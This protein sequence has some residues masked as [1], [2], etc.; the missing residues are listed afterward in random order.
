[1]TEKKEN[2]VH[3]EVIS[4]TRIDSGNLK[5][6]V[7]VKI[8]EITIHDFRVIQQPN[9]RAYVSMPQRQYTTSDGQRGFRPL[10]DMPD[11]L[12]QKVRDCVLAV[13]HAV[14]LDGK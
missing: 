11:A 9:Q 4:M 2:P 7:T 10:V 1:M 8:G 13:W 3:I 6:Y 12:K 5:A 14:W